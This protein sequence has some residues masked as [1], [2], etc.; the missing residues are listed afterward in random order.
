[1]SFSIALIKAAINGF[2]DNPFTCSVIIFP[3]LST[4]V[5]LPYFNSGIILFSNIYLKEPIFALEFKFSKPSFSNVFTLPLISKY[6][7]PLETGKEIFLLKIKLLQIILSIDV[8]TLA[9][10][11]SGI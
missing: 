1:M 9:W 3:S 10:Y 2:Y 11:C 4:L 7:V 6:L 5:T 8:N